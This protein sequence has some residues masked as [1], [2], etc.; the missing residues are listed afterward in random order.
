MNDSID[1][2][3]LYRTKNLRVLYVEDSRSMR[4]ATTKILKNYFHTID[5]AADGQEGYKLFLD[6][7][8]EYD[9]FYDILITDLEMPNMDGRELTRRALDINPYQ[10]IIIISS[11]KDS[12]D[13]I[14]L[15]NLGITKFLTKP[16]QPELLQEIIADIANHLYLEKLKKEE[17][18][19]LTQHNELLKKREKAHLVHLQN[20]LKTLEEFN[21]ALNE[22]GIVS[23]TD[24]Q[25]IITYVNDSF[26]RVSGYSRHELIGQ[27]HS[28]INSGEMSSS[29]FA[30]LWNTINS[31]KSYKGVF[32]NRSK[33]GLLYYAESLIKP[34]LDTKGDVTEFI[35]IEHDI[36]RMMESIES[37]KKAEKAKDDFF[38]NISHEMRT[39]L[40]A[41]V[42]LTS[43]LKRRSNDDS[44]LT[45]AL[46]IIDESAHHLSQMIKSILDVQNIQ[47]N[48]LKLKEKEFELSALLHTCIR[49]CRHKS[50]KKGVE[51]FSQLN[52]NLP[53]TLFG[54]S[55]RIE[56]VFKEILDNAFKFTRKGGQV[57]F[58]VTF[59][60]EENLLRVQ[61]TDTGIGISQEDQAK[62]YEI[63][64]IDGSL[65]R[66]H[67]GAG[68]GLTIANAI[69]KKMKGSILIHSELGRGSTFLIELPLK[70]P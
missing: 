13:L 22:S 19:D 27:K 61:I 34:I 58:H 68:L 51:F 48:L 29:F 23:K 3:L 62:I 11:H 52:P 41:I 26:C 36:T 40:N 39:P 43:L 4:H 54:D 46:A 37:A 6:Y 67:E 25:G 53:L 57:D 50:D 44:K 69:V 55:M 47:N 14:D 45:N 2:N 38:R 7:H 16:I 42:G 20:S 59:D 63:T 21:D 24:T 12:S 33:N 66:K 30:K 9:L 17:H 31:G 18:N 1:K 70:H 64:Q 28:I 65:A 10:E 60:H 32:K 56:Q 8:Q 15:I 35:A 49:S 5:T